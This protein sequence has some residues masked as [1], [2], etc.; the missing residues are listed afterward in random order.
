VI[1]GLALLGAIL[2]QVLVPETGRLSLETI[3]EG[4]A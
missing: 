3:T 4:A 1:A 2:T